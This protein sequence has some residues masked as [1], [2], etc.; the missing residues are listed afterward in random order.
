[1]SGYPDD[2]L[3]REREHPGLPSLH[4]PFTLEALAHALREVLGDQPSSSS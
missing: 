2:V 3:W 4:K 1:M